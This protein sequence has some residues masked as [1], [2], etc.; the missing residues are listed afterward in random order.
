MWFLLT[1]RQT[2]ITRLSSTRLLFLHICF[3]NGKVLFLILISGINSRNRKWNLDRFNKSWIEWNRISLKVCE[4][5]RKLDGKR[6]PCQ[7]V[8][9][10]T[11]HGMKRLIKTIIYYIHFSLMYY[12]HSFSTR[13]GINRF[14]TKQSLV[15]ICGLV[16]PHHHAQNVCNKWQQSLSWQ[17]NI[18]YCLWSYPLQW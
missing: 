18:D 7:G 14:H 3:A 12:L 17:L 11:S 2:V 8:G 5:N 1:R 4:F 6:A 9:E 15:V 16:V 10:R 13:Y